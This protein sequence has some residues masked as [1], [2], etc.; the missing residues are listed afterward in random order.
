MP[1]YSDETYSAILARTQGNVSDDVMKTEGALVFNALSALAYELEKIYIQMDFIGEQAHARTADYDHLKLI[2]ADRGLAPKVATYAEVK[3]TVDAEM[4]IGTRVNLK[5]F[6]YRVAEKMSDGSYRRVCE[7]SGSEPNNLRGEV[8]LI[9]YVKDLEH[10]KITELLTP[11]E[12]YETQENFY[13]RYLESF[14]AT[15]F[16]GN[17]AAYK[18]QLKAV[19]GIGGAKIYPVWNGGGTVKAVLISSD[20]TVPS[21]YL[22][23]QVQEKFCPVPSKGYGLAPI[24]HNFTAEAVK[25]VEL[26]IVT[27]IQ[28]E[29]GYSYGRLMDVLE[30]KV[31]E[32]LRSLAKTWENSEKITVYIS[33]LEAEIL[34]VTG[35]ADIT[36]TT[37]NGSASNL[38]L[39]ADS[40]PVFSILEVNTLG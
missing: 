17:V 31:E 38:V 19:P 20:F 15:S 6:N 22:I 39:D 1:S 14:T 36:N 32:Y 25:K 40:I 33:K 28:F 5:A 23:S 34:D 12:D 37:L 27:S 13:E 11:G 3:A 2:A 9:D 4:P 18:E 30:D 16:A 7:E 24:G 35:V 10:C 26:D 8:T 29:S 21:D